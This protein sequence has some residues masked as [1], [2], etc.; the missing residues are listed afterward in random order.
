MMLLS[1]SACHPPTSTIQLASP[2]RNPQREP[3]SSKERGGGTEHA[4]MPSAD[5]PAFSVLGEHSK[6][7]SGMSKTVFSHRSKTL[8]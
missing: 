1:L 5:C 7:L 8:V 4:H 6:Q 2:A 3:P